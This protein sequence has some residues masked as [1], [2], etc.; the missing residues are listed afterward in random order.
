MLPEKQSDI[1][2]LNALFYLLAI[3]LP[4]AGSRFDG[5]PDSRLQFKPHASRSLPGISQTPTLT[6]HFS[7]AFTNHP[8]YTKPDSDCSIADPRIPNL[9][10]AF[11]LRIERD[12]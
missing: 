10:P 11:W 2:I 1:S 6:H 3:S 4:C 12:E 8:S 5:F 9:H 7:N